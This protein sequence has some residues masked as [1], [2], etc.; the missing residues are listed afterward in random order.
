MFDDKPPPAYYT[1]PLRAGVRPMYTRR[2]DPL[3]Y[4]AIQ[5]V[6]AEQRELWEMRGTP[7]DYEEPDVTVAI[8]PQQQPSSVDPNAAGRVSRNGLSGESVRDVSPRYRKAGLVA[9]L[10]ATVNVMAED[11]ECILNGKAPGKTSS[12]LRQPSHTRGLCTCG[13]GFS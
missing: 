6:F 1:P 3:V 9:R 8:Q 2:T 12:T 4:N 10:L 13:I 7:P 11:Y 5:E